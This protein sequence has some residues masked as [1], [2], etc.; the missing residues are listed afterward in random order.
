[1]IDNGLE[2][3]RK[4]ILKIK[5]ELNKAFYPLWARR[6]SEVCQAFRPLPHVLLGCST[7]DERLSVDGL[8]T[9]KKQPVKLSAE[10]FSTQY[11]G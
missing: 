4:L 11:R 1:M 2:F 3:L 10:S 8:M 6:G 5:R 9:P 7:I